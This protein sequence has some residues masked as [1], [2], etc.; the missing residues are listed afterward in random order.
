MAKTEVRVTHRYNNV[1]AQR[2]FDAWLTPALAGRFL[3]A[4]RTGNI[5]HCEIDAQVGGSFTVTD[6]RPVADGDESFYEAQHRGLFVEIDPPSRLAFDLSIEPHAEAPTRV[7][8]DVVPLGTSL[9]DLVLTH[10]LG[11][12]EHARAVA[13]RTRQGWENMLTQLDKVLNTRSWGGLRTPG[14]LSRPL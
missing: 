13:E 12:S 2:V 7:T 14:N 10:D 1:S 9:C 3:F 8:V 6:R 11:E 4:T 5:L